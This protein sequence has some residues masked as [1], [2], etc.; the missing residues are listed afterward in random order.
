LGLI[1][2]LI[3]LL[4]ISVP[5]CGEAEP[6]PEPVTIAFA[7]SAID[8]AYY[9]RLAEEFNRD[10]P[11]VTVELH[12]R[13]PREWMR[14]N[15]LSIDGID[16][17]VALDSALP[18]LLEQE[19]ILNL[20]PFLE[21]D[22]SLAPSDFYPG[23]VEHLTGDG[24]TWAIPAGVD[25]LVMFYNQDLFDQYVV[26]YPKLGW[27]W[28]DFLNIV[29]SMHDPDANV[30]GY[31]PNDN[32]SDAVPF[33]YQHGGRIADD[34][35]HPTRTTFDD[36]LAIEAVEWYAKLIH[37]YDV[38]PTPEEARRAFGGGGGS[39]LGRG[40][41]AGKLGMWAG[42]FSGW[43]G[44]YY[45]S[46]EWDMRWGMVPLPRDVASATIA[47]VEGYYVSS[48][49]QHVD[50]CWRW[51]AFLSEQ[52]AD[53]LAPARRSL[54]ESAAYGQQVG[55]DIAAV[56]RE[57]LEGELLLFPVDLSEEVEAASGILLQALDEIAN[58]QTTP[59]EALEWA[60][61]QSTFK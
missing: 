49:A 60:Q 32:L 13:P 25:L 22:G 15:D 44:R 40:F 36:P 61:Q 42:S 33:I 58:G 51:I 28:D 18:W 35:R 12:S 4:L 50:A 1:R 37:E 11:Y 23:M 39:Y 47:S 14:S 17:F 57:S 34:L 2:A 43:G 3:C 46:V 10:Q 56:V 20:D 29:L 31:A 52:V 6:T 38:V 45:R 30:F 16:V 9:E 24:E 41:L 19:S 27:T 7:H 54:V 53:R 8:T 55:S 5:G 48:Q 26:P 59:Q 21:Q